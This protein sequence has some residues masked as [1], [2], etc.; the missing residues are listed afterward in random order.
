ML[1]HVLQ[2]HSLG[3]Y[4]VMEFKNAERVVEGMVTCQVKKRPPN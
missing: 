4:A 3:L 2:S 1:C